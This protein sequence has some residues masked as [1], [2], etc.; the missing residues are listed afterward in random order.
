MDAHSLYMFVGT[1]F[2]AWH[3][4]SHP[5]MGDLALGLP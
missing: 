2:K 5:P 4:S 1:F 3:L